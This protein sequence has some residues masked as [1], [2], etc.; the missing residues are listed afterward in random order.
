M[1]HWCPPGGRRPPLCERC[2]E[3]VVR[4]EYCPVCLRSWVLAD[5]SFTPM[6]M[7]GCDHCDGWVHCDCERLPRGCDLAPLDEE[8]ARRAPARLREE[9]PGHVPVPLQ[10]LPML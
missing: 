2:I 4:K 5:G 1:I 7:L 9:A 8:H 3:V 6:D 10:L